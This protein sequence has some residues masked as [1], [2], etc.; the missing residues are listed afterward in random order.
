MTTRR[1]KQLCLQP[2]GPRGELQKIW[3]WLY[4]FSNLLILL[5]LSIIMVYKRLRVKNLKKTTLC[6]ILII[7]I[8]SLVVGCSRLGYKNVTAE[9]GKELIDVNSNI[10]LVDVREHWEYDSGHIEGSI[11][12]PLGELSNRIN[13]LNKETPILLICRTGN[14]S[15]QAGDL[16]VKEGFKE[17]YNLKS[18]VTGWPYGLVD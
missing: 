10:Q 8:V 2:I 18:G 6:I 16:L 7:I 3:I 11:L 13:E 5:F 4:A 15:S 14:R 17:V 12:I 9:E 1:Q